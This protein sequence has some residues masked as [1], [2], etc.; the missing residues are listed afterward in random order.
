MEE[1]RKK[2]SVEKARWDS[3]KEHHSII[4][5]IYRDYKSKFDELN[6]VAI[7][8]SGFLQK[9][10]GVHSVRWRIK[11]PEHLVSKICR[12][13]E[14]G[15]EKYKGISVSNYRDVITDLIGM[16]VLHLMKEDFSKLHSEIIST[17][18]VGEE[19][20]AYLR[21][22]DQQDL[23]SLYEKLGLK[24]ENHA[25]GYR[26]IHY[27]IITNFTKNS[28]KCEL[29]VRTIFEEGWS[30]IDHM[31]RYPDFTDE[32]LVLEFVNIF[33]RLSGAADEMGT[34]ALKLAKDI[35]TFRDESAQKEA[36]AAKYFEELTTKIDQLERANNKNESL[37]A[38]LS[39]IKILAR[40]AHISNTESVE[41][42][43]QT[44]HHS[45]PTN[46]EARTIRD[47]HGRS[48]RNV[49]DNT[50][51]RKLGFSV[52]SFDEVAS[53]SKRSISD[54]ISKRRQMESSRQPEE[55]APKLGSERGSPVRRSIRRIDEN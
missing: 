10:P 43:Y 18:D 46:L 14:I 37:K 2:C 42:L 41:S 26:S 12:K 49:T 55:N 52:E 5:D 36:E 6:S 22:G 30:E 16:R 23:R 40:K 17:W 50:L 13:L 39:E 4:E 8:L 15:T 27:I 28:I 25:D 35:K 48:I 38:E 3:L 54:S 34:F 45:P 29:Q 31:I 9:I 20:V 51:A 53:T 44:F 24:V 1:F 21:D 47:R 7:S 32:P 33:N 11:S 19:P